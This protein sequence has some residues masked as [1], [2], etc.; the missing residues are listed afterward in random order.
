MA[1]RISASTWLLSRHCQ[2][3]S[4]LIVIIF[5][6]NCLQRFSGDFAMNYIYLPSGRAL[7]A[8]GEAPGEVRDSFFA[9]AGA[10]STVI[11]PKFGKLGPIGRSCIV[12]CIPLVC[13]S[14]LWCESV[15]NGSFAPQRVQLPN[16]TRIAPTSDPSKARSASRL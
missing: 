16:T 13:G 4:F 15:T 10:V 2:T 3:M 8:S 7:G 11:A 5:S 9:S 6:W 1:T 14:L 12:T